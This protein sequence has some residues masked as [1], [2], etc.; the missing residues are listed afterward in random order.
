MPEFHKASTRRLSSFILA[1]F[2]LPV[3]A[4]C[5]QKK[6]PVA[7]KGVLDLT[8][9]N[10]EATG[11]LRLAGEWEFYWKKLL[12]KS[13]FSQGE[14]SAPDYMK[15]P[16]PWNGFKVNNETLG[17]NGYATYRLKILLP[18]GVGRDAG[19]RFTIP[20]TAIKV[21][22]NGVLLG[23]V[24]RVGKS[25]QE[26]AARYN[27]QVYRIPLQGS[28]LELTAQVSNFV[29]EKGGLWTEI[30]F[31]TYKA[32]LR[33]RVNTLSQQVFIGGAIFIMA[34]Y[35]FALF[36]LRKKEV[37]NLYF[38]LSCVFMAL[39]SLTTGEVFSAS[40][41][42]NL[43][44]EIFF[45]ID[46][47]TVYISPTT[48]L[49]FSAALY[50]QERNVWILRASIVCS[51][52]ATLFVL[53]TPAYIFSE[54]I[55]YYLPFIVANLIYIMYII[56]TA[57]IRKRNGALIFIAGFAALFVLA[58]NDVLH[59]NQIIDTGYLVT[60]GT[61]IF[62]F[63]QSF[64]LSR[65]FSRAFAVVENLTEDL[66]K[67]NTALYRFIPQEFLNLLL[68]KSILDVRLGDQ[69]QRDMTVLFADIRYFTTLSENMTPK[70]S[71]DFINSYLSR[72]NPV[73]KDNG[74]FIDKYI[75]DAIMA[76]FPSRAEDAVTSSIQMFHELRQYNNERNSSGHEAIN[77][78]VGIHTGTLMLGTV[79]GDDRMDGTVISEA[80]N[81]AARLES[82][83]KIYGARVLISE[84]VLGH[85]K[86]AS[87]FRF[88]V[89]DRVTVRGSNKS[90]HIVE[91]ID[92][93]APEIAD[94][95]M[96][97]RKLYQD[98]LS[99]YFRKE[100]N[101]A[102]HYFKEVLKVNQD[103]GAANLLLARTEHFD[104]FGVPPDWD[105]N[106]SHQNDLFMQKEV[107]IK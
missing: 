24:G 15:L 94:L 45:K 72:M 44:F 80:V 51:V 96:E 86:D 103:D 63:S 92:G 73:I 20:N 12:T 33:E 30:R 34:L 14:S 59:D 57:A 91:V 16:S 102:S 19:I 41:L 11:P 46:V 29:R 38:A 69:V 75:G 48:M 25:R 13:D 21:W 65:R 98:G 5:V 83:T 88:R 9:H 60:Y 27:P 47:L 89:L 66:Q 77:I 84:T 42:P 37:S 23:E 64:L 62:I 68:K 104:Q 1:A 36:F 99:S 50:P 52:L 35:H 22:A 107:F 28:T 54:S 18:P 85:I 67:T 3:L 79:G 90:I 4:S 39:R 61:F 105:T 53:A 74:G 56:V 93:E 49:L 58:V 95:K 81:L 76:L 43:P 7:V 82:L 6:P 2:F 10:Y 78:G 97:T 87:D 17:P 26:M 71:F 101:D 106:F 55:L 31:G 100:F 70:E 40:A 8:S 32:L